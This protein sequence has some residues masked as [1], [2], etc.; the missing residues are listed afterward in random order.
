MI[1][2][3]YELGKFLLDNVFFVRQ[4]HR[5]VMVVLKQLL[6]N[7][8]KSNLMFCQRLMQIEIDFEGNKLKLCGSNPI[9]DCKLQYRLIAHCFFFKNL[10]FSR[11][12]SLSC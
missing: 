2:K 11:L 12:S 10:S 4:S 7:K 5:L 8:E 9:N 1:P 3:K 6:K